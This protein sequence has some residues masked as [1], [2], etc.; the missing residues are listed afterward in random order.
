VT[1]ASALRRPFV[2]LEGWG[3]YAHLPQGG[4]LAIFEVGLGD[5][6]AV[7]LDQYLLDDLTMSRQAEKRDESETPD[8]FHLS[9][10]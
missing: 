9:H 8:C 6:L 4:D 2:G 1:S 3:I 5:D 10:S 7:D